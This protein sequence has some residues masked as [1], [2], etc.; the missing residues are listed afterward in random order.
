MAEWLYNTYTDTMTSKT[1]NI[2]GWV[3]SGL[4]GLMLS[5]S[6]IDKISGT[7]HAIEMGTSF[8]LTGRT[9]SIL[10]VIEI[11]SVALFIYPRTGLLGTL[12]LASYLGGAIATHL[13]HQQNIVFSI[14]IAALIWITSV[15][16]FPELT[17]RISNL[18]FKRDEM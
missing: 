11:L 10:G 6:A 1:K 13:Q 9:Y 8:G 15:I 4:I 14:A 12:L 7:A 5:A 3:L 17:S 2:I 18:K 16:R